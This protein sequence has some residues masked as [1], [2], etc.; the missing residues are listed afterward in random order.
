MPKAGVAPSVTKWSPAELA[1]DGDSARPSVCF[2]SSSSPFGEEETPER[3][4]VRSKTTG[5]TRLAAASDYEGPADATAART[6]P[7]LFK[8]LEP[9]F[10][11][12]KQNTA[13]ALVKPASLPEAIRYAPRGF[14]AKLLSL[15]G[16]FLL[17]ALVAA[18]VL[19][20]SDPNTELWV[21]F[22]ASVLVGLSTFAVGVNDALTP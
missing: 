12:A 7:R 3:I 21:W 14:G 13:A 9:T 5:R 20:T 16:A 18:G 19:L 2:P 4:L 8:A 11:S 17:S 1:A 22:G 10:D 15:I 6:S